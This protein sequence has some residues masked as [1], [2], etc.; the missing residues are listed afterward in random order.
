MNVLKK[1]NG[2]SQ[3]R[4][5]AGA[6]VAM[7]CILAS[8]ALPGCTSGDKAGPYETASQVFEANNRLNGYLKET[9]DFIDAITSM[10]IEGNMDVF[11]GL[12]D[13]AASSRAAIEE[14]RLI[15]DELESVEFG[16]EAKDLEEEI[17]T[18]AK[19]VRIALDETLAVIDYLT[20][21]DETFNPLRAA[22]KEISEMVTVEITDDYTI[23]VE[24]AELILDTRLVVISAIKEIDAPACMLHFRQAVTARVGEFYDNIKAFVIE[25]G[26]GTVATPEREDSGGPTGSELYAMALEELPEI[27]KINN[28]DEKVNALE[29]LLFE[30]LVEYRPEENE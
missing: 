8:V 1:T 3:R 23:A 14:A 22:R 16:A 17:A 11:T 19:E 4:R 28:L 24:R 21:I 29:E 13:A 5:I 30:Y 26:S 15:L 2:K 20:R 18:Y 27:L 6:L 25:A 12:A 10:D 9:T 7:A